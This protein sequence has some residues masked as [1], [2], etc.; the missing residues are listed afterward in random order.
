MHL[1]FAAENNNPSDLLRDYKTHTSKEL[2]SAIK[3]HSGES[4]REWLVWMFE[5]AGQKN[6]N[7]K[8]GQFWQQN[9]KPIELWSA[10]VIDQKVDYIHNNPVEAGF[11]NEPE[12]WRYSSAIDYAGGKG[13]IEIDFV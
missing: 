3:N 4:R 8:N 1:I 10:E 2:Q 9:N 5:R 6:S 11:V 7:V 13:L 12:H